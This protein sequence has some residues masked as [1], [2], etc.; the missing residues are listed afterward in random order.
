METKNGHYGL[1]ALRV[2]VGIIFV[3]MGW[4]KLNGGIEGFAEMLG[5]KGFPLPEVLAYL[6]AAVEFL[7]GLGVL[8]GVYLRLSA[9]LLAIVMIV[10]LLTVHVGMPFKQSMAPL[11]LLGST[12]AL[13]FLGGGKWMLTQKDWVCKP[14]K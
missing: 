3:V 1:L 5:D 11:A 10:A 4:M 13:M 2:T 7:G 14:C 12:L 8:F 9:K 6:V